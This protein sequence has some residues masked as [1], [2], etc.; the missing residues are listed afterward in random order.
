M[1][2]SILYSLIGPGLVI[3]YIFVG[4]A[5]ISSIGMPIFN[6]IKNPAG[7]VRSLIGVV[8]LVV[9]FVISYAISDSEVT[10]KMAAYGIDQS[11][12]KLIGAGLIMFYFALIVA[13]ILAAASLV[14]DI[15]NN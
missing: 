1:E 7:L 6:A 4:L 2:D 11:S 8:G 12:S 3:C 9:L 15:I 10:S 14:R 13:A 5:L